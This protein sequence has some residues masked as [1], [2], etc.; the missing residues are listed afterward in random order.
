[1]GTFLLH[2]PWVQFYLLYLGGQVVTLI[3]ATARQ[4]CRKEKPFPVGVKTK[5]TNG[6]SGGGL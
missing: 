5:T 1:M 2:D 4:P 6:S 3:W